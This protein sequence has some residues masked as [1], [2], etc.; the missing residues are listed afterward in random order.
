MNIEE[1]VKKVIALRLN[2]AVEEIRNTTLLSEDLGADSLDMVE[3]IMA[4]E[5]EFEQVLSDEN[6]KISTV[7]DIVDYV[8][9][10][11]THAA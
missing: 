2:V 9:H 7:Q 8:N 4:M 5:E 1:R 10:A 3:M 11:V 6:M